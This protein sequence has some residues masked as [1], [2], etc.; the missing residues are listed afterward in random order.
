[1]RRAFIGRDRELTE[2]LVGLQDAIDGRGGLFLI[3]G[4]PGIGKTA[5][6]D[7]LARD[8]AERG[9]LVLWSRCWERP[10]APPFWPWA[11]IIR[12]LASEYDDQTLRS[13]AS[14]GP[15]EILHVAPD[16]AIRLGEPPDRSHGVESDAERFY[17]FE[18]VAKCLKNA[19]SIRP[20]LIVLDD[21]CAG[22]RPS[23]LLLQFLVGEIR[24]SRMLVVVTDRAGERSSS[25]E[26]V[27]VLPDLVRA[28]QVLRLH[29]LDRADV[30]RLVEDVSGTVPW[31]GKVATIHK[32][33]GGNP[34]FVREVTR[35][36]ATQDHLDR[37]G[38][39]TISIPQSVRAVIRRRISPLSADAVRVLAAAAVVGPAFDIKLLGP[40]S[41]LPDERVMGSL[42]EA[43]TLDVVSE[44][45]DA[46]GSYR[47]SHPL[48]QEVI[49]D[50]LPIPARIQLHRLVG[51][52]IERL[53]G[54]DSP[55]HLAQLAHHFAKVAPAGEGAKARDYARRAGDQAMAAFAYEEAV[56]E[57]RR[58]LDAMEFVG[59]DGRLRCELLLCLGDAQAR[60]GDYQEARASYLSAITSARQRGDADQLALA[61]LGFGQPQVEA[62][63]VD[64]QLLL[65]L[66]EALE[67]LSP[68]DGPL[69]ARVLS[70][71]SLEL[72][73][74]DQADLRETLSREAVE[75]GRRV[76][77]VVS[78]TSAL[79]A[80]W[81][82][83]WGPDGLDE[84]SGLADEMLSLAG[85]TDD[86]EAELIG[87][88]RRISCLM[89]SGGI[90][91]AQADIAAHAELSNELRM[92]YHQWTTA[93]MLAMRT[94]LQG[95]HSAAE[96]LAE[97]GLAVLPARRDATYAHL[98]QLTLI[99][100]D[101]GR[102]A[103]LRS[104]WQEIVD[105]FPQAS[106]SR[107]WLCL[108]DAE[109]GREDDA[110][111]W[112]WSLVEAVHSFPRNG[113]WLP[114]LAV[115]AVAA[116]R[117]GDADSAAS[118]LPV[119]RPYAEQ[120]VVVPVPHPV[121]CLGSA[122]LYVAMLY[123]TMSRWEEADDHFAAAIRVNTGL[124]AR[125]LLARTQ[126]EY[127][128]M[129]IR[130]GRTQDRRPALDLLEGAEATATA[131]GI[132]TILSGIGRLRELDA[133]TAVVAGTRRT[134]FRREGEYW[135]VIYD[136][137]VVRLR[138]SKGLRYLATLLANPGREF[139]AIDLEVRGNAEVMAG[140]P[141]LGDEALRS[142]ELAARSD[143]G[144]A[145]AMLDETAKAAY[146]SRLADL[147]V[148][149]DEAERFNDLVRA[150]KAQD[151][152]DLLAGE[153]ARAVGLG[154]RD[155]QAA[156][157]AERAR[158][159]VTRAIRAAMGNLAHA[160]PSL[161]QHL[162]STIRTGRYCT[163]NPD[164]RAEIAWEA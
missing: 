92:P 132:S 134:S 97:A 98:A 157:H 160:N 145:G 74:S 111:R 62:G 100:W 72:T 58:A 26:A 64:R 162:S 163:Y 46:V 139:H 89:E 45:S 151:E 113:I 27:D 120:V 9:A 60:A 32:A 8:A 90:H 39:L 79:R 14:P 12:A 13:F 57:Y 154:G 155:R 156:S 56:A 119:L 61:A 91:S 66:Q 17:V 96:E 148:E 130:S 78:L 115:A 16:L 80:R 44:T 109:L 83:L 37:P 129:L 121:V 36:V 65:L 50:E 85:R 5:L 138:D 75:M 161:G 51:E 141:R 18:V 43:M 47:F 102:L 110:Q 159:N 126:Y 54:R 104:A 112:L 124:G 133:G 15:A 34:L 38:R 49:Y 142:G 127:A 117:L 55:F 116:A 86:P 149:L 140:P 40:A 7:H 147:R 25:S 31:Q 146:R 108:A 105:Q 158:L 22:D 68:G 3:L 67:A 2:L 73:F 99:R 143:L 41:E 24:N 88:A 131:L 70:R 81:M 35:L 6:A 71:L 63:V 28:G 103:E 42:S 128:H 69:R 87:R 93:S 23:L 122:S 150:G 76:G 52:A 30:G 152:I 106:F 114:A 53:H 107:G 94:L 95:P 101:Q 77:E 125:S 84:R 164:P 136:G 137:S 10:G 153:L 135:T 82:A 20:L 144:S 19:A 4:E 1:M 29:G 11:Q 59:P 48:M 118:V 123:A 33:T 21:L